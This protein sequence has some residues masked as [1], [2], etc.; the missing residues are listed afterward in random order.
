LNAALA[1]SNRLTA[2]NPYADGNG[3]NPAT[4][5]SIR[6]TTYFGSDSHVSGINLMAGGRLFV[7]PAGPVQLAAGTEYHDQEFDT[8]RVGADSPLKILSPNYTRHAAAAY[9]EMQVPLVSGRNR[10][11]GIE[12]LQLAMAAR[13]DDFNDFGSTTTPR[14]G[15]EWA[16]IRSLALHGSW[17][18]SFKAPDLPNLD[19]RSNQA[20]IAP[21]PDPQAPGGN[22]IVLAWIGGNAGLR[23]ETARTWNTG[24]RWTPEVSGSPSVDLTYYDIDFRDR[25]QMASEADKFLTDLARYAT[26]TYRNPSAALRAE[27]CSSGSFVSAIPIA[28]DCLTAHVDALIDMR[29]NNISRSNTRGLDLLAK[30]DWEGDWGFFSIASNI[31]YVLAF[32]QAAS[33]TVASLAL[34]DTVSN[35]LRFHMLDQF[36]WNTGSLTTTLALNYAGSYEDNLSRPTRRVGSWT[37][38]NAN[39]RYE[40]G[41][42]SSWLNGCSVALDVQNLFDREPP[43]VNNPAGMGYDRENADLWNRMVSLRFKKDW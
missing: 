39:V 10:V 34:V 29:W 20:I 28:G 19:E 2:F 16:P 30:L 22:A 43:F 33:P 9:A 4:L 26:L 3:T 31:N 36:T 32:N 15:L 23:P 35:P 18:K 12:T 13:Y 27:A 5:D 17:G 40:F 11:P 7:L 38:L 14:I 8:Y 1:D 37:T 6:R 24:I 21:I 25:I 41:D 42:T